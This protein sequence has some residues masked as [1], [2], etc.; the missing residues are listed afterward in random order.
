MAG[1]FWLI[2]LIPGASALLMLI[3]GSKLSRRWITWQA[4]GSVFLSLVLAKAAFLHLIKAGHG[5]PA[6]SKTLL[7]WISSGSFSA[8]VTFA[9]DELSAVMAV[10]VTGVGFL[11]HVYSI[12]YMAED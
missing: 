1:L 5:A 9:F 2:P 10:V 11:I 8:S 4:S 3:F 7:P 6:L 12:G